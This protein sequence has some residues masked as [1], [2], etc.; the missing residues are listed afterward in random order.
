MSERMVLG[1][2]GAVGERGSGGDLTGASSITHTHFFFPLKG[3]KLLQNPVQSF[4]HSAS[5]AFGFPHS[6]VTQISCLECLL[7]WH[8]L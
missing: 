7:A 5:V 4:P 8:S 6:A 2:W 1:L 3:N